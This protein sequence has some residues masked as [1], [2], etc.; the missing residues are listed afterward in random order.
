[1]GIKKRPATEVVRPFEIRI[2]MSLLSGNYI[3]MSLCHR[4]PA[5]LIGE[6]DFVEIRRNRNI[7]V[8]EVF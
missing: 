2:D 1:M 8:I 3:V 7:V 4:S 6:N 5:V